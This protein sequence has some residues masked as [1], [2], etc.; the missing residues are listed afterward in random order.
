MLLALGARLG[1]YQILNSLGSGGMGQVYLADDTRLGRKVA[2]K[3]LPRELAA[4]EAARRRFEQEA[5]TASALNHPHI[6]GLLD[7]GRDGDDDFI[8]MEYVDGDT[9]RTIL[10]RGA[11]GPRR[12]L[13]LI[14]QA[15]SGLAA[16]HDA[17]IVHRDIKPENLIVSKT[18]HL[19]ILDFGLAK[20]TDQRRLAP[21]DDALTIVETP[22]LTRVGTIV[23]T[24]GYMSPEQ[25]QSLEV[26][27]RTDIFS[28]GAVLY[29]SLT[30]DRAFSGKSTID[31][32]HA[33]INRDPPP[34]VEVNP[35]LPIELAD[36]IAKALAKDPA[37]RY[38]HAADFEL[39]LR[40]LKR[41]ME[42]GTLP[43]VARAARDAPPTGRSIWPAVIAAVALIAAATLFWMSR[44][45]TTPARGAG[46]QVATLTPLTADPGYEGEPTF[47]PDGETIAYVSDRTG[48]QE[49]FLKQVSGGADVN[50]SNNPADDFQPAFSP[51]G[52][53]MVFVSTRGGASDRLFYGANVS[54]GGDIWVMPALGGNARRIA[55]S[56]SFPSW[57]P[58]GAEILYAGGTWF[59]GKLLRVPSSGG[60]PREIPIAFTTGLTPS[61]IVNPAYSP[62]GRW[63]VF[64][65]PDEVA[66]VKAEGGP[67]TIIAHGQT[68]AWGGDSRI[69]YS[70]GDAGKNLSLWSV[71]FDAAS[72]RVSG[73]PQPLTIGRGADEQPSASRDGK[74]IAFSAITV[75]THIEVQP[76]DADAGRFSG[77]PMRLTNA[78][79]LIYFFDVS[80]D[81]SAALFEL[82]RGPTTSVGRGDASGLPQQLTWDSNYDDNNPQWSPDGTSIAFSR[83]RVGQVDPGFSLW[84]MSADGAN[85]QLLVE[86]MGLNGLFTWMPDGR[87]L[88]HVGSG[89]QLY[90]LDLATK[91]DR[92]LTNEPGVMPVVTVSPD[93]AWVVYQCVVGESI[94]LHAVPVTGGEPRVVVQGPR[95]DYHPSISASGRWLYYYPDHKN[96]YRVP[97]PAQE[98]RRAEPERIT[99]WHLTALSFIENPQVARDGG[100]LAYSKGETTSDVWLMTLSR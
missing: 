56:G 92:Q 90:L 57:S 73:S 78:H 32:L 98:W 34:A 70:N 41:G 96:L 4:D 13:E 47:S 85:P 43:S 40:R 95:Q 38:R 80:R 67:A 30:G 29:E 21:A 93:S 49:L 24:A 59:N 10:S 17:Q 27:G 6:V 87:G 46:E 61:H 97:G 39:D 63:I 94:D 19:K 53:Q 88:V 84:L 99:D 12:A 55:A 7:V 16:A 64:A 50:V 9:L 68:P 11:L 82:R 48:N 36:I 100:Q 69:I 60:T 3:I 76:F 75:S 1:H 83:R 5:R 62:D 2:L 37:D 25:A 28:L 52:R 35:G 72:G 33:V 22:A 42:S 45:R 23:G 66:V 18:N 74:R 54:K 14:A 81:G 8:V 44:G 51:D 31:T 89:R 26:D 86:R 77:N 58:N 20:L 91:K 15:A 65:T 71:P 79:D